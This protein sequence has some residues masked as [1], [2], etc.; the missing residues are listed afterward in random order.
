[1]AREELLFSIQIQVLA[2]FLIFCFYALKCLELVLS[3]FV[4]F[5]VLTKFLLN[6]VCCHDD[7]LITSQF[8]FLMFPFV[9][10]HP[11]FLLLL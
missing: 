5:F 8:K 9:K 7:L 3:S 2:H 10:P 1:M 11:K 6:C 4:I